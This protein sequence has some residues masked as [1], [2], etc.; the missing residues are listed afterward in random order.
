M[1][2]KDWVGVLGGI[3]GMEASMNECPWEEGGGF[4]SHISCRMWGVS[5]CVASALQAEDLRGASRPVKDGIVPVT[6]SPSD[7]PWAAGS[8]PTFTT[9]LLVSWGLVSEPQAPVPW[10]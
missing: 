3:K 1:E 6:P 9:V 2:R 4:S 10:M 7:S 8:R 5:V